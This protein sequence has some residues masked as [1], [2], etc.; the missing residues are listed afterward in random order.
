KWQWALT[1]P[2]IS[3]TS[4]RSILL[5]ENDLAKSRQRPTVLIRFPEITTAPSRIAGAEIG[6]TTRARTIITGS[7]RLLSRPFGAR[8]DLM[9]SSLVLA[10]P[11]SNL[12]FDLLGNEIDGG[13]E[14]VLNILGEQVRP[15]HRKPHRTRKLP[16][17]RFGLIVL[18]GYPRVDG[19]SV[20]MLQFGNSG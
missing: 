10:A 17:R 6:T 14:V 5:P 19:E 16:L 8:C 13:I 7:G 1:S 11:L 12:L 20:Q 15:G 9:F 4:P 2:G 3:T 18:Q